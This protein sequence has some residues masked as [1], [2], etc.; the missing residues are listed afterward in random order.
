[1]RQLG[2]HLTAYDLETFH[3]RGANYPDALVLDAA[4]KAYLELVDCAP[5]EFSLAS[6]DDSETQRRKR[7]R[8][9]A[10][11]QAWLLRR[12][13][14]GHLVPDEPTSPGENLRILPLPYQRVPDEQIVNLAAR[15]KRLF[16][17]DSLDRHFGINA[18]E[19]LHQSLLDLQH[20][21]ELRELGMAI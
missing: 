15:R 4:L 13:Y 12:R 5:D 11:R 9:R 2:R 3:H 14:E 19:V 16:N 1:L 17:C 8:R 21:D 18:R 10:L 20:A 7:L 6:V